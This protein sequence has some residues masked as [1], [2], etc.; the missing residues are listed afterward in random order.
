MKSNTG[1]REKEKENLRSLGMGS[2]HGTET[3][4]MT[5][6]LA[7]FVDPFAAA[8][9]E[10]GGDVHPLRP[11]TGRRA[12]REKTATTTAAVTAS[13]TSEATLTRT[14][15]SPR[16]P[17][18]SLRLRLRRT[19]AAAAVTGAGAAQMALMENEGEIHPTLP[20]RKEQENIVPAGETPVVMRLGKRSAASASTANNR[21]G[22]GGRVTLTS[23]PSSAARLALV[24]SPRRMSTRSLASARH[25]SGMEEDGGGGG[26]WEEG[27]ES[28]YIFKP[29]LRKLN[30]QQQQQ[31]RKTGGSSPTETGIALSPRHGHGQAGLISS[32][33]TTVQVVSSQPHSQPPPQSEWQEQETRDDVVAFSSSPLIE[34][35]RTRKHPTTSTSS[36]PKSTTTPPPAPPTKTKSRTAGTVLP[37]PVLCDVSEAYGADTRFQPVGFQRQFT[38]TSMSTSGST[39]TSVTATTATTATTGKSGARRAF[40]GK[41]RELGGMFRV[42]RERGNGSGKRS[43][44]PSSSSSSLAPS[45]RYFLFFFG[46]KWLF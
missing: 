28:P 38:S 35:P 25:D 6:K 1:G 13:T 23:A 20:C 44:S 21:N 16:D 4:K 33:T 36:H 12:F 42:L 46:N 17:T 39:F 37:D 24:G 45:V 14:H 10:G 43:G 18:P 27:E 2:M 34:R 26:D 15:P 8:A 5:Q 29:R 22:N 7:V 31:Q 41:E 9:A 11:I 19:P 3:G 40:G 30:Q 32:Q